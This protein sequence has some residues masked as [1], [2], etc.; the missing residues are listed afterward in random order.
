MATIIHKINKE[1][2]IKLYDEKNKFTQI[3]TLTL[4]KIHELSSNFLKRS[5]TTI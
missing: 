4:T 3:I 1:N 5:P 2:C